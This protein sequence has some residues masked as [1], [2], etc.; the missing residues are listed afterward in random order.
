MTTTPPTSWPWNWGARWW[1]SRF[2]RRA[3]LRQ[4]RRPRAVATPP[5]AW[6]TTPRQSLRAPAR[7]YADVLTAARAL[8]RAAT[9]SANPSTSAP[10]RVKLSQHGV[11]LSAGDTG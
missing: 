5:G 6:P 10:L 11:G 7:A 3:R 8:D 1:G 2:S 4:A 9:T